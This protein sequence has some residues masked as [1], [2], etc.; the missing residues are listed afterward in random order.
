MPRES[1]QPKNV[2]GLTL[3]EL[4]IVITMIGIL[5]AIA[6]PQF[7][8]YKLRMHD[9]DAKVSLHNIYL[10]CKAYW[11]DN[12][13]NT[14]CSIDNAKQEPYGFSPSENVLVTITLGKDIETDFEATAKHNTSN[15]TYIIDENDNIS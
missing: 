13:G 7:N 8:Q 4:L 6:I 9:N 14:P 3:I 12:A 1:N 11:E 5:A 10:A 2:K 15:T